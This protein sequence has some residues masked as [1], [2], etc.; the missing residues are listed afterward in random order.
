MELVRAARAARTG[1]RPQPL[2]TEDYKEIEDSRRQRPARREPNAP[3]T[4]LRLQALGKA[5]ADDA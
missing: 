1:D 4:P 2:T 3:D 5:P